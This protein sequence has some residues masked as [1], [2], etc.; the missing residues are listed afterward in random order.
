MMVR[1]HASQLITSNTAAIESHIAHV[2][3]FAS[4]GIAGNVTDFIRA[5]TG[6]KTFTVPP[7]MG[8]PR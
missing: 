3:G 1:E 2:D 7:E 8:S 4:H 5:A 6:K